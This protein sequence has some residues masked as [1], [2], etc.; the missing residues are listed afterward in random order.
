MR[1]SP[2]SRAQLL[3]ACCTLRTGCTLRRF[4]FELA[5]YGSYP[6]LPLVVPYEDAAADTE[7]VETSRRLVANSWPDERI[8]MTHSAQRVSES[9][10]GIGE[11]R[12]PYL[13][14]EIRIETQ[15][16][17]GRSPSPREDESARWNWEAATEVPLSPEWARPAHARP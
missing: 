4:L 14:S 8:S 15:Q 11:F 2:R 17:R 6:A 16:E 5:S 3:R 13:G 1:I 7:H 9:A 10:S 12:N